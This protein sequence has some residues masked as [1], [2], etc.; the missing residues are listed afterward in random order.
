V[1]HALRIN[2]V[3]MFPWKRNALISG[4]Q[5][6][7]IVSRSTGLPLL[8]TTG[9]DRELVGPSSTNNERPNLAPG[10]TADSIV[11]GTVSRWYN[12][13]AFAL[14]P[15]G[16]MG[17]LGRD[18]IRGPGFFNAD[19]SLLKDTRV[20]RLSEQFVVQFR[21]EFFNVLNHENFGTPNLSLFTAAGPNPAAGQ[22][23]TSNPGSIPRQIQFALKIN[24]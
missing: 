12:P 7:G 22:I 5:I 17:N 10:F 14:Q 20:T 1:R 15:A 9:F 16:T 4:W 13:A 18:V 21:A 2:G 3:Y 6:S 19:V 8:L 23:T 11:L 24:F